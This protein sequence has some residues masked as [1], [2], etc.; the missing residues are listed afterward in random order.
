MR[1][2]SDSRILRLLNGQRVVDALFEAGSDGISRADIAR[3]TSLSKPT[4]SALMETFEQVGLVRV[5]DAMPPTRGIGR[6]GV[7]YEVAPEAGLVVAADVGATKTI[8]GVADLLGNVLS[9]ERISTARNADAALRAVVTTADKMLGRLGGEA[10]AAC[11]GV[12]GVY[13]AREDRV[14]LAPNL[15]GFEVLPIKARLRQELCHDV[16]VD[17]DVNL[18]AL[19]EMEAIE[20]TDLSDFAAISVGTGVGLGLVFGGD[21][22]RG[23]NGAV[24]EIGAML[25]D[26]AE[27][28]LDSPATLE[29]LASG[30]AIRR[31]FGVAV[32]KGVE[33]GLV[34][35]SDVPAIF[36]AANDGDQAAAH[37]VE[38]AAAAMAMAV[39]HLMAIADPQM[40]VF[41][42]GVGAN[43]IF[44]EAVQR[45]LST[46]AAVPPKL[47][48]ST[49][50][51]RAAFSGA[52]LQ[53][54]RLLHG[55][56]VARSLEI[57]A[58]LK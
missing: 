43:P 58:P 33:T 2:G 51:G 11:I 26:V 37:A 18:A 9:E 17:N 57:G 23:G 40:I 38:V 50:G 42:G 39:S 32:R 3:A 41:G 15:P 19:G 29:D 8:V 6:P 5:V 20:E 53:A 13:Q 49:L 16:F 31:S 35:D 25:I 28:R 46:L 22:Y 45:R 7:L 10:G 12:P 52:V 55:S 54:L 27:S 48:A 56:L 30:P 21:V 14:T 47:S 4:V 36:D 34:S 44:L 24:G 1:L